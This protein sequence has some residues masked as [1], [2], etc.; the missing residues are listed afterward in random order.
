MVEVF[1]SG[2]QQVCELW[3]GV[4]KGMLPVRDYNNKKLQIMAVS[5]CGR[6]LARRLGWVTPV[7]HDEEGATPHPGACKFSLQYDGRPDGCFGVWVGTWNEGSLRGK[8]EKFV[9][10]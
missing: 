8:G 3:L 6:Q 7:Y 9:K 5:Y 4:S 2:L 10:N 1:T